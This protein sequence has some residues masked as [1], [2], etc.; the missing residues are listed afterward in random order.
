ME[1]CAFHF[2]N[3]RQLRCATRRHTRDTYPYTPRRG[4]NLTP[5]CAEPQP[6]RFKR[7][8]IPRDIAYPTVT[9]RHCTHAKDMYA[10]RSQ[11]TDTTK[12]RSPASQVNTHPAG[13][14]NESAQLQRI[15]STT[16]YDNSS[17]YMKHGVQIRKNSNSKFFLHKPLMIDVLLYIVK[18]IIYDRFLSIVI[19]LTKVYKLRNSS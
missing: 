15:T 6:V 4:P 2:P 12:L 9:H 16:D 17:S 14:R 5:A 19:T 10:A 3:R 13:L 8:R 7:T 11:L 18:T 1:M